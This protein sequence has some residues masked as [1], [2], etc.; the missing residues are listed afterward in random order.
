MPYVRVTCPALD[1]TRR[2]EIAEELTNAVVDPSPR[3]GAPGPPTSAPAP[4]CTSAATGPDEL[5]VGGRAATEQR[6]DITV[7]LSDCSMSTRIA[8]R[9]LG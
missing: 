8:K 7:E 3:G 5:F 6:P 9:L 1:P 2:R 4:P